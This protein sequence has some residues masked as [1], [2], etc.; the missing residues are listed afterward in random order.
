MVSTLFFRLLL[1]SVLAMLTACGTLTRTQIDQDDAAARHYAQTGN[2]KAEVDG[3]A[4]PL[5]DQHITPG[6]IVGV[7]LPDGHTQFFGYGVA[8]DITGQAPDAGTLFAAGSVSKGFLGATAAVLV[9]EGTLSWDDTLEKLLPANTPLSDDAKKITLLQL[10]THTSG[11]PRQPNDLKTFSYFIQY[12]FDGNNFYRHLD[13]DYLL[14]YLADFDAPKHIAPQ[15]SN[16]GYALL[17]YVMELR[18]GKSMDALVQEK[19]L[20]P[21]QLSHTGYVPEKLPGYMQRAQGHAGD[22]PKFIRRGQTLADWQFTPILTGSAA[23][24]SSAKDLLTFASFHLHPG[25]D[26]LRNRALQDTLQVRFER[27]T[28]A[29][30]IAWITDTIDDHKITYQVGVV[31]GYTCYLGMDVAHKTAVVVLQNSLNWTNSIGHR[32]LLRMA[33]A[34]ESSLR[35]TD[36][37]L[38]QTPVIRADDKVIDRHLLLTH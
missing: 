37:S 11:L 32:L 25:D 6:L 28:E 2:L 15:Y 1:A 10:A 17:G 5:I 7:L 33:M 3:L 9:Q 34:K 35:E 18:T 4:Q 26:P 21:L 22:Q 16:I 27:E 24:Y 13:R 30:D 8:N 38:G 12:L 29:A 19:I 31:S 14:N 23:L 20:N 36:A